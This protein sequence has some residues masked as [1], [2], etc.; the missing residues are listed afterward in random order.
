MH[1]GEREINEL[2][3][4]CDITNCKWEGELRSVSQHHDQCDYVLLPCPKQCTNFKCI[5]RKD[6][7]HHQ[8]HECQKREHNCEYC[9]K[10]GPY[11]AIT[12]MHLEQCDKFEIQCPNADCDVMMERQ[13]VKRHIE[14]CD[15]TV[16]S[17]KYARLGCDKEMK[18]K[19]MVSHEEDNDKLH[20]EM[21][22]DTVSTLEEKCNTL[23]LKQGERFTFKITDF[24]GF[25][26]SFRSPSFYT[27]L[28]GY[29]VAI[30]VF[31]SFGGVSVALEI[32]PGIYDDSLKWPVTGTVDITLLN[33]LK[34]SGHREQ[35]MVISE[36]DNIRVG[37]KKDDFISYDDFHTS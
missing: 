30:T 5:P 15:N 21:G 6:L 8:A 31:G 16:I 7:Q 37:S 34:D 12:G 1:A 4:R 29:H 18:R 2:C 23:V 25:N 36:E 13:G 20:L 11:D 32:L 3:V 24:N 17:C 22:L 10:I 26:T 28:N 19:E 35:T 27:S 14:E 9:G 33:Q